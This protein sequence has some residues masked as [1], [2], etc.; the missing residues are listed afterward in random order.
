MNE[1]RVFV[2]EMFGTIRTLEEGGRILFCGASPAA[3]P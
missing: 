3:R 1:L 2:N